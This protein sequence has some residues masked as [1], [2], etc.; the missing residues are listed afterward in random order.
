[1]RNWLIAMLGVAACGGD[2]NNEPNVPVATV[3]VTPSASTMPA[4]GAVQLQATTQDANGVALT[5]RQITWAA[6]DAAIAT[7][8][9]SGT[10]TGVAEGDATITATSEGKTGSAAVTVQA[11]EPGPQARVMSGDQQHATVNTA[12]AEPLVVEIVNSDGRSLDLRVTFQPGSCRLQ[13]SAN[14][15]Q[16]DLS[17]RASTT[18]TKLPQQAGACTVPAGV[19]G[20]TGTTAIFT[21]HAD[22]D[23]AV[24]LQNVLN[25]TDLGA[26]FVGHAPPL[27][28]R[29]ARWISMEIPSPASPSP[30]R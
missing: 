21:L 19:D 4:G 29:P 27:P 12:P 24:V 5:G 7:V 30:G 13:L 18:V 16:T 17:G 14:F 10:V 20:V 9:P 28:L 22:P 6:S 8:S 1:M 3:T 26:G 11:P 15:V 25:R 23:V 2:D